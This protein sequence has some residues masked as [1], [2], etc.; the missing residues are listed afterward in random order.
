VPDFNVTLNFSGTAD[1]LEGARLALQARLPALRIPGN[2]LRKV[3]ILV[4]AADSAHAVRQV[5]AQV[6]T[7]PADVAG[8]LRPESE[9]AS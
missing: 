2:D 3:Y 7:L 8:R 6:N 9:P 5:A 4:T 1:E